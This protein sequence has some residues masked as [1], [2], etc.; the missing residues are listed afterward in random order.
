MENKNLFWSKQQLNLIN[1]DP[2]RV[3]F[4]SEFGT[5]K[6]TLLK[7]K[8]KILAINRVN[9]EKSK[10]MKETNNEKK[11]N[12]KSIT[13]DPGKTFL[14][15]FTHSA[16]L[17]TKFILNEFEELNSHVEVI[18]LDV[19]CEKVLLEL[20][21]ANTN[22]NFLMDEVHVCK[23]AISATTIS[24]ISNIIKE[25]NYLWI[26]CQSDKL[27]NILDVN[28]KGNTLDQGCTT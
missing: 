19:K 10:G 8:A 1:N 7:A 15:L 27:P 12:D 4:T 5:G 20:V 2:K 14:I 17:L 23:N 24:T 21:N 9:F 3:L 13:K 25:S 11:T 22:C 6:T 26:A 18:T 16:S 28:F